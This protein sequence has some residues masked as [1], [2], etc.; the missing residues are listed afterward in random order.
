MIL[1]FDAS[2]ESW[3]ERGGSARSSLAECLQ[4]HVLAVLWVRK[5]P[6]CRLR[7]EELTGHLEAILAPVGEA[8]SGVLAARRATIDP[9]RSVRRRLS[10]IWHFEPV[11]LPDDPLANPQVAPQAGPT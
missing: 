2:L 1:P 11:V 7:A 8:P 4:L 3:V 6:A 9:G 10:L 5:D